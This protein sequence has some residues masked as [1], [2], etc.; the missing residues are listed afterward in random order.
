MAALYYSAKKV[1]TLNFFMF[2]EGSIQITFFNLIYYLVLY[3]QSY[4]CALFIILTF[5]T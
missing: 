1:D 4:A 3:L 5:S 2:I